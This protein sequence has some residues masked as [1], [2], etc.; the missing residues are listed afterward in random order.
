[1]AVRGFNSDPPQRLRIAMRWI[2]AAFFAAAGAGHLLAPDALLAITPD[3]V[4]YPLQMIFITGLLEMAGAA[5]LF[6]R[7]RK[8]AGIA[9]AAY[10][11]C[12]WPA[13]FKH[14]FEATDV[15]GL[16]L[17]WWYHGPRLALQPVIVWASL[18]ASEITHWPWWSAP[19]R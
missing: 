17:S 3:W 6:T 15:A 4:P 10:A 8:A 19:R 9:L 16:G 2:L 1:M 14:A 12:V 5:A 7:W 18:F 13:N 11:I